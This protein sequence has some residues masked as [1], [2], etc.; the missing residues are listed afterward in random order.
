MREIAYT[1]HEP[2]K[3]PDNPLAHADELVFIKDGF[4][5]WA[6]LAPLLWLIYHRLWLP[7]VGFVAVFAAFSLLGGLLGV[8]GEP[9]GNLLAIGLSI[10]FGF[11]A[12]DLRRFMLE[13]DGYRLVSVVAGFSPEECE[14]R[15]YKDWP[16]MREMAAAAGSAA[17]S[18]GSGRA[19]KT[20][21][22]ARQG[23]A[24]A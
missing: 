20:R 10:G 22:G 21:G 7:L 17:G 24:M 16:P 1:V 23:R 2:E 15:F 3:T 5:W 9:G 18:A 11:I 19:E 8:S 4:A 13:R 14:R 12:N 6:A